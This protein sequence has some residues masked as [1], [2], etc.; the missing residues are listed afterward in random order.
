MKRAKLDVPP[1]PQVEEEDDDEEE[2][3]FLHHF[4]RQDRH[5]GDEEGEEGEEEEEVVVEEEEEE[6]EEDL[7]DDGMVEGELE[8]ELFL[9]LEE[10][11][12]PNP[13]SEGKKVY[14]RGNAKLP[15]RPY[16]DKHI[17]LCPRGL[18]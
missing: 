6:G 3:P 8:E 10:L 16:A 17:E 13:V 18:T 14:L 11:P 15:K 5:D 4:C 7:E 9:G 1:P 2:E 12:L